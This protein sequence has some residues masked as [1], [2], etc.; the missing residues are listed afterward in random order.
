MDL[1]LLEQIGL[2]KSE[3]SVYLAL[4]ELGSSSTGKI[5]GKAKIASSK[6]YEVLDRLMDK[7]LVSVVL[8]NEV[9]YFEAA[10]PNRVLDYVGQME[11]EWKQ[12][13]ERLKKI[14]PE[15]ELKRVLAESK[16]EA[17]IYRGLKGLETA[18]YDALSLLKIGDEFLA[19]GIPSRSTSQNRFFVKFT[20]IC[21]QKGVYMKAIFN[22]V[23]RG[24]QQTDMDVSGYHEVRFLPEST[25]AAVNVLGN[26]TII[27][28]ESKEEEL[29]IV[30][31]DKKVAESF[32]VQFYKQWNQTT[33]T[34]NGFDAVTKKFKTKLD[35]LNKGDEYFVLGA[36]LDKSDNQMKRWLDEFHSNRVK[37]GIRASLLAEHS[38]YSD[39]YDR[40][41][42]DDAQLS[43][44]KIKSLSPEFSAPFQ[45]SLF[46]DDTVWVVL[47]KPNI[48]LIEIKSSSVYTNFKKYFD[49]LWNQKARV[50]EGS[51][52]IRQAI[53]E[54]LEYGDYVA[55]AEGM[56]IL[57]VLGMDFFQWWQ[58]E[59]QKRNIDSRLL[60]GSRYKDKPTITQAHISQTKFIV[61]YENPGATLVFD[62]HVLFMNLVGEPTATL[63]EDPRLAA[64]QRGYFEQ[65]WHQDVYSV[66]GLDAVETIFEEMLECGSADFLGARGYFMDYRPEFAKTWV[67]RAEKKGFKMRN[68]TDKSTT[69]HFITTIP[70][71]ETKYA[72]SKDFADLTVFWIYGNK[73]VLSNWD[74]QEPII[75]IIENPRIVHMYKKQFE[76]LWNK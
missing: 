35:V 47:W 49:A 61:G 75:T 39:I 45:I 66:K 44:S 11:N 21:R 58:N 20:R 16:T 64:V 25:P 36:S 30:I 65:L 15:L 40:V 54:A 23:A 2:T 10:P 42:H 62:N 5:V 34:Y 56:K 72:L 51:D 9:K 7:G 3:I 76:T 29:L 55:F 67:K 59:K 71:C 69:N 6:V 46:H 50:F 33:F 32:R 31:D 48:Q 4:L 18:F 68:L 19:S 73:V 17:R 12:K 26:R 24:D 74:G 53:R 57:D 22:E 37:K 1:A 8:K 27:F 28:P 70:F 63:I 52:G 14:I 38:V 43:I 60:M 41:V 13:K